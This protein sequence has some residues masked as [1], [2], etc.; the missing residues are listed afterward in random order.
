LG[1]K[2]DKKLIFADTDNGGIIHVANI[3]GGV[4]KSTVATN[5]GAAL[6]RR[7]PTLIIDL[8]VQGSATHALGKDP[9]KFKFSSWD[10]FNNRFIDNDVSDSP[11]ET[12]KAKVI[13]FVHHYEAK[14]FPQV[15]GK[16]KIESLVVNIAP[17]LDLIPATSDLFNKTHFYHYHNFLYNIQLCHKHYK[18]IIL[19]TPSVWNRLTRSLFTHSDL[20]LIPVTLNAL[21]TRSLFDYLKNIKRLT[22]RDPRVRIRIVKNEV[23]GKKESKIKGKTRTMRENRHFL[24][25]LCEQVVISNS[26]GISLLPQSIIF[27]LEIPESATVHNAQD[28]GKPVYDYRQYS[29][30]AKAFEE[31]AKHVQYVLNNPIAV[32]FKKPLHSFHGHFSFAV[33]TLAALIILSIFTINEPVSSFSVPRPIVPQHLVENEENLFTYTFQNDVPLVKVVKYV[34]CHYCAVVPSR[35]QINA[36]ARE[37]IHVHNMTRMP[38]EQKISNNMYVPEG[39]KVTFYPPSNIEN[40][41]AEKLTPVYKYFTDMVDDRFAYITGD[42]CERGTG[43]GTPHY[44]ID[45]AANFGTEIRSPIDGT[46][47]IRNSRKAG[48]MVGVVRNGRVIFFAHMGRRYVNSGDP[49]KKGDALGTVGMTGFTS[50]PHVHIGYGLETPRR[51]GVTFGRRRYKQT[52]PKLFFYREKYLEK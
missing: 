32:R 47:M 38:G 44:G 9:L 30:V 16:K 24:E 12:I 33:K 29:P 40:P 36:Y 28:M 13:K 31:L 48:R 22:M 3:K 51:G 41:E 8:D 26:N 50:G 10:L 7:G 17:N 43:G 1:K 19:D 27:D 25:S 18:Y 42:W 21:S 46:A 23:F 15:V 4:G 20:N 35:R 11:D 39:T 6:S 52:D 5:L 2:G 49:V 37:V 34:I 45:V 14:Y